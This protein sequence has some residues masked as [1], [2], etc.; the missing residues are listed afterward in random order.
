MIIKHYKKT[1][2]YRFF[3]GKEPVSPFFWSSEEAEAYKEWAAQFRTV[4]GPDLRLVPSKKAKEFLKQYRK[5]KKT[6]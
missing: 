6:F 4:F 5:I 3:I 1:E 2:R